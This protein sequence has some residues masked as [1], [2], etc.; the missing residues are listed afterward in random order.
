MRVLFLYFIL[1][2][3]VTAVASQADQLFP[4]YTDIFIDEST[5]Y[6]SELGLEPINFL[7]KTTEL[8][9]A[10]NNVDVSVMTESDSTSLFH[11][12]MTDGSQ[13]T[14]S[15]STYL[16]P[17]DILDGDQLTESHSVSSFLDH[18]V[19]G[20][21]S[22]LSSWFLD[23][24][25]NWYSATGSDLAFVSEDTEWL[26]VNESE[27]PLLVADDGV[28]C[29]V[30]DVDDTQLFGKKRRRAVCPAPPVGQ[31]GEKTKPDNP[32]DDPFDFESFMESRPSPAQFPRRFDLCPEILYKKSTIPVCF[33][34]MIGELVT[35][36]PDPWVNLRNILNSTL[37]QDCI[38]MKKRLTR[39][40]KHMNSLVVDQVRTCGVANAFLD[41]AYVIFDQ[42]VEECFSQLL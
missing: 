12:V 31:A 32:E 6:S 7:D 14:E 4:E 22:D 37:V 38:V 18:S 15:Y 28:D 1:G 20:D 34:P 42:K 23:N 5:P 30:G 40:T 11:G 3:F 33:N 13:L 24:T 27:P 36:K 39:S 26:P 2:S 8:A 9:F 19:D 21:G 41:E 29:A 10:P 25:M 17:D 35:H 16:S